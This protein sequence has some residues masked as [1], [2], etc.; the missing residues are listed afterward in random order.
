MPAGSKTNT[1]QT[2]GD[3]YNLYRGGKTKKINCLFIGAK[4]LD[5]KH[6]ELE[7]LLIER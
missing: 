3:R 7:I 5:N 4:H 2:P 1:C 6:K